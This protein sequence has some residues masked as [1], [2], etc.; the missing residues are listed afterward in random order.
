MLLTLRKVQVGFGGLNMNHSA[1]TLTNKYNGQIA[2]KNSPSFPTMYF[3]STGADGNGTWST[4][5]HTDYNNTLGGDLTKTSSLLVHPVNLG[6]KNLSF[7]QNSGALLIGRNRSN[8]IGETAF[9]SN[10][11]VVVL[12]EALRLEIMTILVMKPY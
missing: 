7:L 1:N 5:V 8:H 9:I 3:R 6:G 10:R 2:I 4:V 11:G 12:G